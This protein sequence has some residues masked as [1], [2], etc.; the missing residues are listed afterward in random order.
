MDPDV[1]FVP[2]SGNAVA[3]VPRV[4][5]R[6]EVGALVGRGGGGQVHRAVDSFTGEVVALKLVRRD[7]R[8]TAAQLRRELT[9]LRLLDLPGVV[10]LLD[11]GRDRDQ[12]AVL[13]VVEDVGPG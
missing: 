1:T 10:P 13:H 3:S 6:Y 12:V 2:D 8:G 5:G 9:A 7:G 11:S 4:A